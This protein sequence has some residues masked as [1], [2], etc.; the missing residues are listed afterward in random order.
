MQEHLA[1]YNGQVETIEKGDSH[2]YGSLLKTTVR[3]TALVICLCCVTGE[4][5]LMTV[6]AQGRKTSRVRRKVRS[7]SRARSA[8]AKRTPA[9]RSRPSANPN[10]SAATRL[11]TAPDASSA[12]TSASEIPD[13][14]E[15]ST[16][17]SVSAAARVPAPAVEPFSAIAREIARGDSINLLFK[18]TELDDQAHATARV[19]L[20]GQKLF[21]SVKARDLPPPSR[22]GQQY[23]VL[24]VD[25]PNY[26]QKLFIGDLP[27]VGVKR[28]T[29]RGDSDTGYFS[30]S[31][32]EGATFGGLMLT[33]EPKRYVPTPTEPLHLL[34]VALPPPPAAKKVADSPAAAPAGVKTP[35]PKAE[36]QK[37]TKP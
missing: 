28:R 30:A 6:A 19:V 1:L 33:A 3:I 34:L 26:G 10:T 21:V 18:R 12:A 9:R 24:W 27:L 16:A 31:I 2:M 11:A 29:Q 23:Y 7:R 32:P 5:C 35:L 4:A 36:A 37:G 20:R 14:A 15:A 17:P 8:S 22:Y 25:L 13:A